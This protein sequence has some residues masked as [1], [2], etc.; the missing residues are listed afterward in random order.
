MHIGLVD[1][2]R[3]EVEFHGAVLYRDAFENGFDKRDPEVEAGV[4]G[5][6]VFS[7]NCCDG[8]GTLLNGNE[9][10]QQ[11]G[12]NRQNIIKPH[13]IESLVFDFDD[14]RLGLAVQE[15]KHYL[16]DGRF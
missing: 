5:P 7:E 4:Q 12:Y 8:D 9:T 11:Q 16:S 2:N 6:A 10:E 15:N 13:K 1:G 3:L 14:Q